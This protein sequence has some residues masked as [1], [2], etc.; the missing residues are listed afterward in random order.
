MGSDGGNGSG[1]R[2]GR[3]LGRAIHPSR[4]GVGNARAAAD[5]CND[6]VIHIDAQMEHPMSRTWPQRVLWI[7]LY[8]ALVFAPLP[9]M[10]VGAAP[11]GRGFWVELGVALGFVA[12]AMLGLQFALTARFHWIA[13][14]F[15][16][17]EMMRF[18]RVMGLTTAAFV[19]GHVLTLCLSDPA[20]LA[21]FDPRV[22][23]LRA[24][25]LS[26]VLAAS[27]FVVLVPLLR[28]QA[29]LAYEWWRV[30]HGLAA[31]L[32]LAIGL[33]HVQMVGHF[34]STP[35]R[36]VTWAVLTGA[37]MGLLIHTRLI[38][39]WLLR[40]RPWR[41]VEVR[42][43]SPRVWTVVLEPVGHAGLRYT[44][45]Q[46]AWV[47][48]GPS[49]W[50]LQQHPFSFSGAEDDRHVQFTIKELGD[51]TNA[52]GRLGTGTRAFVEGPYGTFTLHP[53][54][55]GAVFIAGGIG[56]T[57]VMSILRTLRHR[58][59]RRPLTLIYGCGSWDRI[60]FREELASMRRDLNLSLV[61]VLEEPCDQPGCEIGMITAGVLDRHLHDSA[62]ACVEYFICGPD[63][64]MATVAELLRARGVPRAS[65]RA[66][67]FNIV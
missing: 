65:I 14:P 15:G 25:A 10:W 56:I 41:V 61:H 31:L 21:F 12:L 66:E 27:L 29:G 5:A 62:P 16:L 11:P 4:R 39:P 3:R 40:S 47:T 55:R 48:F 54:A 34:V 44:A 7:G 20:H 9:A 50:S 43:E 58:G 28:R 57:P 64:M 52:I 59:D 37:A 17:D 60:V 19:A 46:F 18:H 23:V 26:L 67:R 36:R 33:A 49:P 24:G 30:T 13:G 53:T 42:P 38:R 32:I 1:T 2:A 22:N 8:A 51:F 6:S 45:G 63:P 35:L